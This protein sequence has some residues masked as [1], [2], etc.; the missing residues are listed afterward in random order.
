TFLATSTT[1][2]T[3]FFLSFSNSTSH[4]GSS[5]PVEHLVQLSRV[6]SIFYL[7]DWDY[8]RLR[9]V[10]DKCGA[11]LLCDVAHISGLVAAQEAANPFDYCDLVT[12]TTHKSLRGPRA[13]MIFYR[14]GPKPPKKGQPEDVVYDYED[15]VNFAVFPSLQGGPHNHQ[16][17]ALVVAPNID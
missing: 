4:R 5:T 14:K 16:I 17:A 13:G 8:A 10:A 9:S 15:K 2:T 6:S 1:T 11:M 7:G 3:P 12:T